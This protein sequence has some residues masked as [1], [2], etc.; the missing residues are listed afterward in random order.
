MADESISYI[1]S[2]KIGYQCSVCICR[3]NACC[4]GVVFS[5]KCGVAIV[6]NSTLIIPVAV[7]PV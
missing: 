5:Y 4:I 3:Y 7:K 2:V 1:V 6:D